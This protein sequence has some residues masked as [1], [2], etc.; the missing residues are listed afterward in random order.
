[1]FRRLAFATLAV[2]GLSAIVASDFA[3]AQSRGLKIQLRQQQGHAAK[4]VQLYG[5]SRALVI[6]VDDY[7]AG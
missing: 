6:G 5:S 1:M 7:Q 4:P 2:W 3:S